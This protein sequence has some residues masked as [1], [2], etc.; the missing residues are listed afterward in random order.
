MDDRRN[1]VVDLLQRHLPDIA[2][3]AALAWGS[4]LRAYDAVCTP[5]FFGFDDKLELRYHGRLEE[6]VPAMTGTPPAKPINSI[7]CSIKW[8]K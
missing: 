5:E 1:D 8:K 3:A 6:L 2:I 7:G 4:G